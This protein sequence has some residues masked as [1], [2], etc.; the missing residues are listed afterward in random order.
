MTQFHFATTS[1]A[2]IGK[3]SFNVHKFFPHSMPRCTLL[4]QCWMSWFHGVEKS[5]LKAISKVIQGRKLK[6][7][8]SLQR[9]LRAFISE[10]VVCLKTVMKLGVKSKCIHNTIF[11]ILSRSSWESFLNKLFVCSAEVHENGFWYDTKE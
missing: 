8:K 9:N 5:L 11:S 7:W 3:S 2:T 1:S 6:N 10:F 4:G